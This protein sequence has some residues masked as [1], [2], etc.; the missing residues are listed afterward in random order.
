[1][2]QIAFGRTVICRKKANVTLFSAFIILLQLFVYRHVTVYVMLKTIDSGWYCTHRN[3]SCMV[4]S[5]SSREFIFLYLKKMREQ[6]L[7]LFNKWRNS[8]FVFSIRISCDV[9]VDSIMCRTQSEISRC[10]VWSVHVY[11]R[12]SK[13]VDREKRFHF[14]FRILLWFC[15]F[16]IK[17]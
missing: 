2:Q 13:T 1:M 8:N 3:F 15:Y 14:V 4:H 7:C 10:T 11:A 16:K 17:L 5:Q 9:A 12:L 6:P